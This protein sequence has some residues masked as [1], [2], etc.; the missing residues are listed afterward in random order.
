MR[1][2]LGS[3]A[4]YHVLHVYT[5]ILTIKSNLYTTPPSPKCTPLYSSHF[6]LAIPIQPLHPLYNLFTLSIQL[7]QT[8]HFLQI[9]LFIKHPS[10]ERKALGL[11][12]VQYLEI[13]VS[14]D[15]L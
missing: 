11:V 1:G 3:V 15:T 7:I 10:E 5:H 2:K 13:W 9:I 14:F 8:R 4:H 6:P 12:F